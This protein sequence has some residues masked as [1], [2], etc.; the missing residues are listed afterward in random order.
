MFYKICKQLYVQLRTR[1]NSQ[2]SGTQ[3]YLCRRD[4]KTLCASKQGWGICHSW[5]SVSIIP[6]HRWTLLGLTVCYCVI[7]PEDTVPYS[8]TTPCKRKQWEEGRNNN[9]CQL[10]ATWYFISWAHFRYFR[11]PKTSGIITFSLLLLIV[12][13]RFTQ[14]SRTTSTTNILLATSTSTIQYV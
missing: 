14:I 6:N 12:M 10:F 3:F 7:Y 1:M 5:T 8:T 9:I 4:K 11:K 2:Q 13:W